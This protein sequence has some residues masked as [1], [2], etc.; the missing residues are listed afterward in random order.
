MRKNCCR[1]GLSLMKGK[2]QTRYSWQD[3]ATNLKEQKSRG[4][5]KASN[6]LGAWSWK[7]SPVAALI[8]AM[9]II[10][11]FSMENNTETDI[12]TFDELLWKSAAVESSEISQEQFLEVL[13]YG[14]SGR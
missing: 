8:S 5:V 9:L 10:T 7:A 6:L 1:P 13:F 2:V 12:S 14:Y 3:F 11:L 4:A